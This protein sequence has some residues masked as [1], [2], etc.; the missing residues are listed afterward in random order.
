MIDN[1]NVKIF[2]GNSNHKLANEIADLLGIEMGNATIGTFSDG[3]ISINIVD[4]VRGKEVYLIQST[5][6]PVNNNLMEVLVMI[7]ALKRASAAKINIVMPYMGYARQDRKAKPH[8]PITAKLVADLLTAAGAD[9]VLSM[10]LHVSQI[11]GFFNIPVDHL[12][13]VPVL[14]SY[15]L[16]KGFDKEDIVVVSPDVGSVTRARSFAKKLDAPLAIIDKRRPKANVSEIMNIIG[17]I[18][19]K[20]AIIIDDMLDTGG[21]FVNAANAVKSKGAKEVYGCVTHAVLSGSA[22]ERIEN[23]C[24][25]ELVITN[26]IPTERVENSPKFTVLSVAPVFAKAIERIHENIAL[27]S[28]NE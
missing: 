1:K 3:E 20:K 14:A 7:D 24:L 13:G 5:C 25:E 6:S 8:D 2:T 18:E 28:L 26:T 27:S 11:Q 9:R 12:K 21:T 17:D 15:Y 19:G 10:D 23:S 16:E 22:I 4:S